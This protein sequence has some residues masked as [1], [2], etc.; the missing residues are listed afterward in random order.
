M[1][2]FFHPHNLAESLIIYAA[3]AVLGAIVCGLIE[4]AQVVRKRRAAKAETEAESRK[5]ILVK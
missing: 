2:A 5:E 1:A 4:L 3:I